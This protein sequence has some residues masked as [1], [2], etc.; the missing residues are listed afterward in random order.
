M[1]PTPHDS[2]MAKDFLD[3]IVE[4]R[5]RRNTDFLD[6]VGKA[7]RR[8]ALARRLVTRKARG[9]RRTVVAASRERRLHREHASGRAQQERR[10]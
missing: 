9:L 10:R 8:L 5:T 3:E 6:L 7:T 2:S 4:E 1:A